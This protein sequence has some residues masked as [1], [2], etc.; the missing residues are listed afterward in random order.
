ML[1]EHVVNGVIAFA[2]SY[3][4]G[5]DA[6]GCLDAL[7]FFGYNLKPAE[8]EEKNWGDITVTVQDGVLKSAGY[9]YWLP[10]ESKEA[11]VATIQQDYATIEEFLRGYSCT[12]T[13]TDVKYNRFR[14]TPE[15]LAAVADGTNHILIS[16]SEI[17]V[18]D[19]KVKFTLRLNAIKHDG[20]YIYRPQGS[21]SFVN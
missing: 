19:R 1:I 3:T 16:S 17:L 20:V 11:L 7:D 2:E 21:V 4:P 10:F 12:I 9:G 14:L 8:L 18:G 13:S 5:E 15:E 6:S